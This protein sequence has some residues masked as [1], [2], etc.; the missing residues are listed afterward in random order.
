MNTLHLTISFRHRE[1]GKVPG[2]FCAGAGK[3]PARIYQQMGGECD[4]EAG[5]EGSGHAQMGDRDYGG[6][7]AD[8]GGAFDARCDFYYGER[9]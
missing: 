5:V 6:L 9:Q 4:R 3:A 1:T 2:I 8:R 7:R